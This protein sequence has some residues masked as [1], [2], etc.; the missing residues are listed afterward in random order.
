MIAGWGVGG[1]KK[2]SRAPE[3]SVV[4]DQARAAGRVQ[5]P[6]EALGWDMIAAAAAVHT[7]RVASPPRKHTT[8]VFPSCPERRFIPHACSPWFPS[9]F[10]FQAV[11]AVAAGS[12]V[13]HTATG[14]WLAALGQR[15][16]LKLTLA[17]L[18]AYYPYYS[19]YS[20]YH[21]L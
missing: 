4:L 5:G 21:Y 3:I 7:H 1:G 11:A 13:A 12:T 20:Y 15:V 9:S 19:Y 18:C 17:L 16:L 8:A 10:A 2:T 14:S 6:A